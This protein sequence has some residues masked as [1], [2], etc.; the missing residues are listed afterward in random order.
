MGLLRFSY[1][2]NDSDVLAGDAVETSGYG[3]VFP[4]GLLIGWVAE[5][6]PESHGLSAYAKVRPAADLSQLKKVY[7]VKSFVVTE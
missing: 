5:V 3:G 1:L 6:L 2:K 7:I 4:K